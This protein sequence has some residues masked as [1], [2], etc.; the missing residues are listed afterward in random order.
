MPSTAVEKPIDDTKDDVSG[1]GTDS[2]SDD[3]MPDL[4]D[5]DTRQQSEVVI[6]Q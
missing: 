3:S 2:D 4:E 1:S 6:P 5:G